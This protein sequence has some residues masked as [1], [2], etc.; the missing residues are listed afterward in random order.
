[1]LHLCDV[2]GA[3]TG[4]RS[5]THAGVTTITDCDFITMVFREA[6]IRAGGDTL[7]DGYCVMVNFCA[8]GFKHCR[9]PKN[10]GVFYWGFGGYRSRNW[11]TH[12]V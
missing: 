11:F 8:G 10:T 4:S 1:M 6:G 12:L 5:T 9:L 7:F 2:I 3:D